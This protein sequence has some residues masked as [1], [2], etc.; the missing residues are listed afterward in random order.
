MNDS[1]NAMIGTMYQDIKG[2]VAS[3]AEGLS[4]GAEHVYG[5]LVKQQVIT[6][7]TYTIIFILGVMLASLA[8]RSGKKAD[9]SEREWDRDA[10]MSLVLGFASFCFLFFSIMEL[11]TIVMGFLNP[12]YGAM[13]EIMSLI[14]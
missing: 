7:V 3:I 4:I 14:K 11:N 5:V 2:A 8:V 9:Y 1:K 12:E 6:S 10:T 13:K